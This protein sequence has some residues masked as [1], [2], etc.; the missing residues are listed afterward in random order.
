MKKFTKVMLI[1]SACLIAVGLVLVT[2]GGLTGGHRKVAQWALN[3]ELSFGSE[4]LKLFSFN[5]RVQSNSN[6]E[7]HV[8]DGDHAEQ[9]APSEVQDLVISVG[10]AEVRIEE[11]TDDQISISYNAVE[12]LQY[13]IENDTLFI[14]EESDH[15][16]TETTII[17][18]S[19][20]AGTLFE[21]ATI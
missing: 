11:S 10:G 15:Y 3:G 2:V 21:T 18:L 4:E 1:L 16:Y 7:I 13:Y 8:G 19:V 17:T 14:I 20:P 6:Y 5:N 12:K 9:W